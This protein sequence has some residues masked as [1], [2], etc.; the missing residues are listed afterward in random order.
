MKCPLGHILAQR[1]AETEY[2]CD[3]CSVRIGTGLLLADCRQ[4]DFSVCKGC[5][6]Q[7]CDEVMLGLRADGHDHLQSSIAGPSAERPIITT[8][9]GS[10][11]VLSGV[12]NLML[13][14]V[15][16]WQANLLR[17]REKAIRAG[18]EKL[19]KR[20]DKQIASILQCA[21]LVPIG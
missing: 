17:K 20:I 2:E 10:R 13:D 8:G 9:A 5:L 14:D 4:F 11:K 18:K 15:P 12:Q 6:K 19:A 1:D 16:K 3:I 21:A 7:V